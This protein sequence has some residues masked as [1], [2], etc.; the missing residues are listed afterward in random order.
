M[1]S[2]PMHGMPHVQVPTSLLP[3][4]LPSTPSGGM[5]PGSAL[6]VVLERSRQLCFSLY[7]KEQLVESSAEDLMAK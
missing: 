1:P 2:I 5:D 3:S 4:P 6:L 7:K